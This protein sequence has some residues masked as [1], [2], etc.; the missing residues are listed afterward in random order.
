MVKAWHKGISTHEFRKCLGSDLSFI[1][2][3]DIAMAER[4]KELNH[5]QKIIDTMK[6]LPGGMRNG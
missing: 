1:I 3:Y 5:Q 4:Q 2:D 6:N